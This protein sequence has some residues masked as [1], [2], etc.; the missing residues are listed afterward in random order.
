MKLKEAIIAD[1]RR[2]GVWDELHALLF[3]IPPLQKYESNGKIPLDK[4]EKLMRVFHIKHGV[5]MQYIMCN[6]QQD[7]DGETIVSYSCSL[8]ESGTHKWI[9]TIYALTIYECFVKM[10]LLS[11][12]YI[13]KR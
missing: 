7:K 4:L 5:Q 11:Y 3:K 1:T 9:G 8:K 2:D 6:P 10:V 13:K 12:G